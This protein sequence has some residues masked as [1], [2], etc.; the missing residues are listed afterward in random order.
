MARSGKIVDH[1]DKSRRGKVYNDEQNG[2]PRGSVLVR[3]ENGKNSIVSV[4]D[5]VHV[6]YFD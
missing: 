4:L 3:W 2:I 6:G 5:L 1:K